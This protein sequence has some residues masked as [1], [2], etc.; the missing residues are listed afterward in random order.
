MR[1]PHPRPAHPSTARRPHATPHAPSC[2]LTSLPSLPH[3]AFGA[4][5]PALL[6]APPTPW[7]APAANPQVLSHGLPTWPAVPWNLRGSLGHPLR[8][9]PNPGR[10]RVHLLECSPL[11]GSGPTRHFGETIGYQSCL[12]D[13]EAWLNLRSHFLRGYYS[14]HL[15]SS[16]RDFMLPPICDWPT[17]E[18]ESAAR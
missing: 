2:A 11:A 5:P 14:N 1:T 12:S 16:R 8:G 13:S 7:A 10:G 3:P 18:S 6:R 4:P 9:A 17:S 15:A